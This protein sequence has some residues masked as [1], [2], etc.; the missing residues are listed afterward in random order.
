MS[1]DIICMSHHMRL[2][3]L[4]QRC[5]GSMLDASPFD[6][7]F[8]T[9]KSSESSTTTRCHKW[10]A[11]QDQHR[12]MPSLNLFM[13]FCYVP[14]QYLASKDSLPEHHWMCTQ[15]CVLLSF[16]DNFYGWKRHLFSD[17]S[18]TEPVRY[19]IMATTELQDGL[20]DAT[21]VIN[22]FV[23]LLENLHPCHVAGQWKVI[24]S[25]CLPGFS[26]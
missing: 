18:W 23:L 1:H 2:A 5:R 15:H 13:A 3:A 7:V 22:A 25:G 14:E 17:L 19:S 10:K 26:M 11:S 20:K 4:V 24:H 9:R 12:K 21:R 6:R 16:Y 8:A